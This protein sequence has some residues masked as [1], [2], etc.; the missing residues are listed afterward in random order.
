MFPNLNKT[1]TVR[2]KEF[3]I[4]H[5]IIFSRFVYV[6]IWLNV[7]TDDDDDL[8]NSIFNFF[9]NCKNAEVVNISRN[10]TWS[11]LF[12]ATALK[13]VLESK[14]PLKILFAQVRMVMIM[15]RQ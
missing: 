11:S 6:G 9:Q 14:C 7:I 3:F 12:V 15:S 1:R 8:R 2:K 13:G 4:F 5:I 10:E